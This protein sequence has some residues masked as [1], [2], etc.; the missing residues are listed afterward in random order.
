MTDSSFVL[1]ELEI[2]ETFID[3][4]IEQIGGHLFQIVDVDG[5][6]YMLPF[7]KQGEA[8]FLKTIIPCRKATKLYLG[9]QNDEKQKE[10]EFR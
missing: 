9:V 6:A 1:L 5:Y 8:Y 7:V 3:R 4:R 10:H 2:G